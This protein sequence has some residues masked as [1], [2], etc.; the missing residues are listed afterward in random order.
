M[1]AEKKCPIVFVLI[2]PTSLI[3][4]ECIRDVPLEQG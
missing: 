1:A 3:S 4:T 2:R